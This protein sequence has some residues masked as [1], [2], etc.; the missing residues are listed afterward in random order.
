[1][2]PSP[3]R[4]TAQHV[5]FDTFTWRIERAHPLDDMIRVRFFSIHQQHQAATAA[6]DETRD[7]TLPPCPSL[8]ASLARTRAIGPPSESQ[9]Q[10]GVSPSGT[11]RRRELSRDRAAVLAIIIGPIIVAETPDAHHPGNCVRNTGWPQCVEFATR[12]S[13][14]P[15][16]ARPTRR[17]EP[18]LRATVPQ[19]SP[20]RKTDKLVTQA[21]RR[22]HDEG[23]KS[24]PLR[25]SRTK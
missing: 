13:D 20:T 16:A 6:S 21:E 18:M 22:C 1:M 14:P 11:R 4:N 17:A 3:S 19:K 9:L 12:P 5:Q 23:S 25:V 15:P 2:Y 24:S 10:R 7:L 8:S